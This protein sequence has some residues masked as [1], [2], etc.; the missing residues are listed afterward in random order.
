MFEKIKTK[1]LQDWSHTLRSLNRLARFETVLMVGFCGV[2]LTYLSLSHSQHTRM[3]EARKA[4]LTEQS[5]AY[6]GVH[7]NLPID[8][9]RKIE[10]TGKCCEKEMN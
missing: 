4:A 5:K 8:C 1:R 6:H 9:V 7:E 10:S 3:L 2:G